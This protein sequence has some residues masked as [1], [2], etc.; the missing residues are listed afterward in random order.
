MANAHYQVLIIGGGTACILMAAQPKREQH[1]LK[2][3]NVRM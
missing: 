3:G 2:T 1:D